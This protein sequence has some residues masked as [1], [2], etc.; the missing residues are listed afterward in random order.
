MIDPLLEPLRQ[1]QFRVGIGAGGVAAGAVVVVVL[2]VLVLRRP[3]LP[4]GVLSFA[5]APAGLY[6]LIDAPGFREPETSLAIGVATLAAAGALP[7]LLRVP[8]WV[9]IPLAALGG[10]AIVDDLAIPYWQRALLVAALAIAAPSAVDTDRRWPGAT[11]ALLAISVG[12]MYATVPDTEAALALLGATVLVAAFGW[13]LRAASL[14]WPPAHS[15]VCSRGW[16]PSTGSGVRRRS[17]EPRRA[18]GCS[19]WSRW[20][21]TPSGGFGGSPWVATWAR[22]S[23]SACNLV[24]CSCAPA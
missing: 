3:K 8:F 4:I 6:A 18:S 23:W 19:V 21:I 2:L 12:G 17:L 5:F 1:E 16:W 10:L 22:S 11:P 20:P 13:P 9:G 7:R 24:S 14:A 15:S